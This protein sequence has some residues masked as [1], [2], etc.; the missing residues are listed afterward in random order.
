M[1]T[2]AFIVEKDRLSRS[3]T[4]EF[5]S[6][7]LQHAVC[8]AL[9]RP[10]APL[11]TLELDFNTI[12]K[13]YEDLKAHLG[14]LRNSPDDDVTSEMQL[15]VEDLL[16]E[17]ALYDGLDMDALR[18][19]QFL[20]A[21]HL[22][23]IHARNVSTG[24]HEIEE[25]FGLGLVPD[26]V[27]DQR[28]KNLN[29]R[30]AQLARS[31]DYAGLRNLC[32]PLVRE[33]VI[34]LAYDPVL[35]LEV[36][37][38]GSLDVF[39]YI[40]DLVDRT[41]R[42]AEV[43]DPQYPDVTYDPLYVAISLGQTEAVR[44]II[45]DHTTFEGYVLDEAQGPVVRDRIFT[46][47]Y[48][49]TYWRQAD[50]VRLLLNSNSDSKS[51]Y[52]AGMEQATALAKEQ[53]LI[54]ILQ[55]LMEC[56]PPSTP[57]TFVHD[58]RSR[59]H[60]QFQGSVSPQ[61]LQFPSFPIQAPP[62]NPS[63]SFSV[64]SISGITNALSGREGVLKPVDYTPGMLYDQ[65]LADFG[66]SLTTPT[67]VVQS[68]SGGAYVDGT[69]DLF[70]MLSLQDSSIRH[71]ATHEVRRQLGQGMARRL[72]E[73]RGKLESVCNRHPFSEAYARVANCFEEPLTVWKSGINCFRDITK[74]K[75]P[76]NI[77]E[78]L[79]MLLV[80]DA[81]GCEAST[82]QASH[83]L[84]VEYVARVHTLSW[85]TNQVQKRPGPMEV[86]AARTSK[87]HV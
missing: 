62:V 57:A 24:L 58:I 83:D 44:H 6:P 54:D 56:P 36:L 78:V 7:G 80:A 53:A 26:H 1:P 69:P 14:S 12:L 46:P 41:K 17:R 49:A 11:G 10:A 71:T 73:Q 40:L 43:P 16:L 76:S 74:N 37:Q 59:P 75:A 32:E 2:F 51:L 79:L 19:R 64:K 47:L 55:M 8:K 77:I 72:E 63:P 65:S 9:D 52:Y 39:K 3:I 15:L 60:S 25:C 29:L 66:M 67:I 82:S 4:V 45:S 87:N 23:D 30:Y 84:Q 86:S 38:A 13:H 20:R 31:G 21:A 61:S 22:Q 35:L 34:E 85:L 81:L 33:R 68:P 48:A 5:T 18:Q 42:T 28:I 70:P 50:I 27:S